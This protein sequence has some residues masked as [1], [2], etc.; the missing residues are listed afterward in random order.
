MPFWN[1]LSKGD[2]RNQPEIKRSELE[3][4]ARTIPALKYE[5]CKA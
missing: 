4:A 3:G 5:V 2:G 1:H